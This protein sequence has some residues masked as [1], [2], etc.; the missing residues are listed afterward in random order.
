[1]LSA[2]IE[3]I[4]LLTGLATSS[5]LVM[6]LAPTTTMKMLFGRAASDT[7]SI[8]IARHWGLLIFLVGQLLVYAAY[9]AEIRV[10]ALIL[11]IVEKVMFA[12]LVFVSPLRRSRTAIVV[13][14]GDTSMAVIYLMCLTGL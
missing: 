12:I 1:M 8:L 2:Q 4:L 5:A 13:A 3:L 11:A 14:L 9:N 10:V 7:V 6:F